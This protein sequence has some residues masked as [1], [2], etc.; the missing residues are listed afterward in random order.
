[1]NTKAAIHTTAEGTAYQPER[2]NLWLRILHWL[3]AMMI[4]GALFM[5]FAVLQA[6]PNSDPAKLLSLKMHMLGGTTIGLLMLVRLLT[7][8]VTRRPPQPETGSRPIHVIGRTVH[9]LFYV[10]VLA[11][12]GSGVAIAIAAGLPD[13][14]LGGQ[15]QLPADFSHI[16]ARMAH[17]L[18][19]AVLAGMIAVH[20]LAAAFHHF[21]LRDG[22]I[23][24]M[25]FGRRCR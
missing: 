8:L 13:I 24:R 5:G 25:W 11:L 6:T 1:M 19:A 2:Y 20:V 23:D 10:L 22:L 15:G 7:R 16:P 3:L 4:C 9:W 17:G 18:I 21:V 12:A 14:V